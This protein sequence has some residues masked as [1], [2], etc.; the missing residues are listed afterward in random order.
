M[1]PYFVV[2]LGNP[3]KKYQETRHNL[4]FKVI[5]ALANQ[6]GNPTFQNKFEA[7]IAEAQMF[8]SKVYFCKPQTY[9]NL[10]GQSVGPLLQFY[11]GNPKT[12]LLVIVDDLDLPTGKLRIR[13]KGGIGWT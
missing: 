7:Q 5:D 4:G 2:G 6:C 3:G 12:D 1:S 11:K 8:D 10:S 13:K 9:M